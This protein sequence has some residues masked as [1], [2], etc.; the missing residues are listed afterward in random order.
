MNKEVLIICESIYHGNTK[1][2]ALAMG[3]KLRCKVVSCEEAFKED[4]DNYKVIGLGSGIYFTS[5]H[6]KL[7]S[8]AEKIKSTTR[9]FIFSTHGRPFLGSYHH[10]L[11]NTLM[12]NNVTVIGEFSTRGYDCTGPYN[13]IGGGNKGKPNERDEI[14]SEKFVSKILPD[15]CKDKGSIKSHE[16]IL[17]N[18]NK[19][20]GCGKCASICPL[21]VF[22]F[23]NGKPVIKNKENC[24]YCSLCKNICKNGAI[25]LHFSFKESIFIAKRNAKKTSL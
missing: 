13:I 12:K 17:I 4:L 16:N 21:M 6:P 18:N 10:K 11:K 25:S 9:V 5:H 3:R 8:I 23:E 15:F 2:I 24:I 22:K 19:C 20:I 7:I 1:K 14:K